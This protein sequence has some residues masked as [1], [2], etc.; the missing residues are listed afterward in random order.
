M[1][2]FIGSWA[3]LIGVILAVILGAFGGMSDLMI[4]LLVILGLIVGFL[5]VTE[6]EVQAFLMAA[7]VLVVVSYFGQSVLQ[8]IDV[9]NNIL[10]ALL[11]L[12]V[13]ATIIVALTSVFRIAK[14]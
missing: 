6:K 14:H 5:N 9:M 3:F 10:R 8:E 4:T 13:P 11:I 2:S 12:F 1:K 7:A